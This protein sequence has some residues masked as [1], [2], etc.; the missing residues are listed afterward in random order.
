M[1]LSSEMHILRVMTPVE[2]TA[3]LLTLMVTSPTLLHKNLQNVCTVGQI[4]IF[5]ILFM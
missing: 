3:T 1:A 5:V 4:Q 2:L